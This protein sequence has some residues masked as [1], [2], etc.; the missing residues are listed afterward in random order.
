MSDDTGQTVSY[1]KFHPVFGAA[2]KVALETT[3]SPEVELLFPDVPEGLDLSKLIYDDVS[4]RRVYH[5]AV[6]S[7]DMK[8]KTEA[9]ISFLPFVDQ[10][11]ALYHRLCFRTKVKQGKFAYQVMLGRFGEENPFGFSDLNKPYINLDFLSKREDGFVPLYVKVVAEGEF[12]YFEIR[13]TADEDSVVLA[14]R[15]LSEYEVPA[16]LARSRP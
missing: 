4:V 14:V 13:A 9:I 7:G 3:F 6:V 5:P 12:V 1:T 10:A 11:E 15:R 16:H 2:L 8:D